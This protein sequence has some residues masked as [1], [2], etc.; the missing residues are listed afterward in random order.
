MSTFQPLTTIEELRAAAARHGLDVTPVG[1]ALDGMGLDFLVLHARD[2]AGTRWVVRSPRREDVVASA[3]HEARALALIRTTFPFAVPDWRIHAPDV[4]AYPR[5]EG[6]PAVTLDTGA[7]VWNHLDPATPSP[8]FIDAMARA[9]A[10]L[11]GVPLAAAAAAGLS[12]PTLADERAHLASVIAT[13]RPVLNPSDALWARWQR[14]L[15]T[16][17]NWPTHVAMVHGDLHPGHMLL[18]ETGALVGVL[19]WTEARIA[20]PS[21]DFAMFHYCFGRAPLDALVERFAA[22]GGLTWPGMLEHTLERVAI[23]PALA[24]E[25]AVRTGNTAVLETTKAQLPRE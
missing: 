14:W 13:V 3:A 5:L 8:V 6:T 11:Q 24:A 17:V 19:D 10:A 1:D 23:W 4:I 16:D 21:V 18:A 2:A 12:I 9:L 25:W 20:D 22:H 15:A 7:P